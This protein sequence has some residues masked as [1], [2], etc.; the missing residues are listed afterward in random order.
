MLVNV[1][2]TAMEVQLAN[3]YAQDP[4]KQKDVAEYITS[5]VEKTD[6][7]VIMGFFNALRAQKGLDKI[8]ELSRLLPEEDVESTDN[9]YSVWI[10]PSLND[11]FP[12][13]LLCGEGEDF[14]N[15]TKPRCY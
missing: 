13:I 12:G 9:P 1:L 11:K 2:S 4:S 8:V 6:G 5:L 14:L 15:R 3:G 7:A 10:T